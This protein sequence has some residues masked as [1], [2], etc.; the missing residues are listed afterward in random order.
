MDSQH[1]SSGDHTVGHEEAASLSAQV[2]DS[3]VA[4]SDRKESLGQHAQRLYGRLAQLEA[5]AA[6]EA[7]AGPEA[8]DAEICALQEATRLELATLVQQ[9][10]SL[11]AVEQRLH[12]AERR[13]AS[14]VVSAQ[15]D[16]AFAPA[17]EGG[18]AHSARLALRRVGATTGTSV[19]TVSGS[20]WPA[21]RLAVTLVLALLGLGFVAQ[22]T[23]FPQS[24]GAGA[25]I[26]EVS[27]PLPLGS[28]T[29]TI[30]HA[31]S[32]SAS[33]APQPTAIPTLAAANP[34]TAAP[35]P[36]ATPTPTAVAVVIPT[37]PVATS[38]PVPPTPSPTATQPPWIATQRL[39]VQTEAGLKSGEFEVTIDYSDGNRSSVIMRFDL[40]DAQRLRH[41]H[42]ASSARGPAGAQT[43]ELLVVGNQAWQRQ[44]SGRWVRGSSVDGIG[45]QMRAYLPNL[46]AATGVTAEYSDNVTA[47][48]WY[49]PSRMADMLLR[50]DSTTGGFLTFEETSRNNGTRVRVVYR[51]WNKPV[52]LPSPPPG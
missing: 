44:A 8:G 51:D 49:E 29:E 42:L 33:A 47:L 27:D 17:G 14:Q 43:F 31:A 13:L 38:T 16:A 2:R 7:P 50:V 4:I 52:P 37:A 28:P 26:T 32:P 34:P 21:R 18:R 15:D 9:L 41:I 12:E 48:R 3:L 5:L 30:A 11:V 22:V 40:G 10:E 45:E 6:G 1:L 19:A 25:V 24:R 39:A 23:L 35:I 36:T 20:Q 46:A